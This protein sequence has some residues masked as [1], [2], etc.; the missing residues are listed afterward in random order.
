[1]DNT[2]NVKLVVLGKGDVGKTSIINTFM[3]RSFHDQYL[4]TIGSETTKK[5][6]VIEDSGNIIRVLVSIWDTGGQK[7]FNPFNPTLYKN[8][9]ICLLVFDLTKTKETLKVLKE[10]YLEHVHNL[11][12]DV[13]R[14]FIGNKSDILANIRQVKSDLKKFLSKNENVILVSAKTG[15]HISECLELVIH[16][17]LKKAE[18]FFPDIVKENTARGFLN[19]INKKESQLQSELI[20]LNNLDSVLK[21]QK[22]KPKIKEIDVEDNETKE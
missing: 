12:E 15:E 9:D 13:L 1:M 22:T 7:S 18:V 10:E 20:N 21:K 5:E 19:L 2:I 4:P 17:F 14:L 6:Y 11:S 3:G 16:T 8:I